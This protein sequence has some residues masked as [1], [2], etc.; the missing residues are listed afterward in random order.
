MFRVTLL[1]LLIT[2]FHYVMYE[3]TLYNV[4]RAINTRYNR[5]C[6]FRV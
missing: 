2:T 6:H 4:L 3:T 5:D 1:L